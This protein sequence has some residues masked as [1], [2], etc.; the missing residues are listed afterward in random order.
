MHWKNFLKACQSRPHLALV[1]QQVRQS[2]SPRMQEAGLRSLG[3]AFQA[4]SYHALSVEPFE[5]MDVLNKLYQAGC[6]GLNITAPYKRTVGRSVELIG[7]ARDI[8][9]VN[10]LLRGP[11]GWLGAQT[12]G[13]GFLR[14]LPYSLGVSVLGKK[15]G[16]IGAGG[17]A[18]ALA[19]S[20]CQA[21]VGALVLSNRSLSK[22]QALKELLAKKF[23]ALPICLRGLSELGDVTVSGWAHASSGPLPPSLKG[24]WVYQANYGVAPPRNR[25]Y[26]YSDGRGLLAFQGAASLR[27]WTG[28][29]VEDAVF[30]RALGLIAPP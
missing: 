14:A 17:L 13:A 15:V 2:P 1:G 30:L 8:E 18:Y 23:P 24:E 7:E 19:Q 6:G 26:A 9:T 21:G 12:D 25:A 3:G 11:S 16:L 20:L 28:K 27:L 29:S 10:T 22:A 5:L 4:W